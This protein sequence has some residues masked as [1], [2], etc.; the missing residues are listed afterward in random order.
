MRSPSSGVRSQFSDLTEQIAFYRGI[1]SP[2]LSRVG[3]RIYGFKLSRA[4]AADTFRYDLTLIQAVRHNR[5]IDGRVQVIIQGQ[6]DGVRKSL[7]MSELAI[8]EG[9]DLSFSFK[10]FEE[11][12]G[13]FKIPTG[14]KP[15]QVTVT[16]VA[17]GAGAQNVRED[18]PWAKSFKTA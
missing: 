13:E 6:Q 18:F 10:Y 15:E 2:E 16:L 12:T 8:G 14:F 9:A 5:K 4:T 7:P 17:E 1:V 3:I 11:L